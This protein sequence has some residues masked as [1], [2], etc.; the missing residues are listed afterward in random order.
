MS[1]WMPHPSHD[2]K[3]DVG[4]NAAIR[5]EQSAPIPLN[6]NPSLAMNSTNAGDVEKNT[7]TTPV[8]MV[9]APTAAYTPVVYD[10]ALVGWN[11]TS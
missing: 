7:S 3:N 9:G 11:P 1:R 4:C 10:P 6:P 2:T 8:S 5:R